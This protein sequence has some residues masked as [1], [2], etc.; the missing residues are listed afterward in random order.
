M[1]ES[2]FAGLPRFDSGS[3]PAASRA[4]GRWLKVLGGQAVG[5]TA[6]DRPGADGRR[7]SPVVSEAPAAEFAPQP[8][9][10][11]KIEASLA[12]LNS[13][14]DRI[15]RDAQVQTLQTIQ[16]VV[17]RLFPELSKQFLAEEI[18][19]HLA[20]LVP[21]SAAVVDIRAEAGLAE[22]LRELVERSPALAHRCTITPMPAEGEGRV[23]VSWQTGGLT[24]DFDGLL[25]SC[26]SHLTSTQSVTKE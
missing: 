18:S 7:A 9:D 23:D 24:F 15:E 12:T 16:S 20:S 1:S 5:E 4:P 2:L 19:R 22:Q 17:A 21:V 8:L 6:L 25:Q 14:L 3:E 10:F 13:K 26:L 11:K